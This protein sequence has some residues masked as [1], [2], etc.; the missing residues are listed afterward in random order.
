MA[1]Q[2]RLSEALEQR[3]GLRNTRSDWIRRQTAFSPEELTGV[4]CRTDICAMSHGTFPWDV[5]KAHAVSLGVPT[6]VQVEDV[7]NVAQAEPRSADQPRVLQVTLSD[8]GMDVVGVEAEAW[9]ARLSLATVPGTKLILQASARIR[10]GRFVLCTADI[11]VLGAPPSN[12]WGAAYD[13]EI[14]SSRTAAGLPN[15]RTTSLARV[16]DGDDPR[17]ADLVWTGG[18]PDAL[19]LNIGGLADPALLQDDDNGSEAGVFFTPASNA[20]S[21][22]GVRNSM[23]PGARTVEV[24]PITPPAQIVSVGADSLLPRRISGPQNTTT[25][26]SNSPSGGDGEVIDLIGRD[27]G[28]NVP[29]VVDEIPDVPDCASDGD[30]GMLAGYLDSQDGLRE[31]MLP[32]LR[33]ADITTIDGTHSNGCDGAIVRAFSPKIERSMLSASNSETVVAPLDDGTAVC[34]M[35]LALPFMRKLSAPAASEEN[36]DG[37]AAIDVDADAAR[38]RVAVRSLCGFFSVQAASDNDEGRAITGV[39]ATPPNMDPVCL[40]YIFS[41]LRHSEIYAFNLCANYSHTLFF[42]SYTNFTNSI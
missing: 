35:Q 17:H 42:P 29:A 14:E 21:S 5:H 39:S 34:V 41:I 25:I 6:L 11:N 28:M 26:I 8:G 23:G 19:P 37:E 3:F 40:H 20:L 9:G 16:L 36:A 22:V 2:D 33:L 38:L 13:S 18:A 27:S 10:R 32:L 15:V 30:D 1:S 4:I 12:I 7:I 24:Q 31:P